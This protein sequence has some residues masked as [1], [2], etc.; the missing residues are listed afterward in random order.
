MNKPKMYWLLVAVLYLILWP[1]FVTGQSDLQIRQAQE[2]LKA[3][4]F[5][6][7][8]LDGK[9]GPKTQAALQQYQ[10][11]LGLPVTGELDE[12]TR[13]ALGVSKSVGPEWVIRPWKPSM[14]E[15]KWIEN[16][17]KEQQEMQRI[18]KESGEL[19]KRV[20]KA[21]EQFMRDSEAIWKELRQSEIREAHEVLKREGLDPGS[22]R[23]LLIAAGLNRLRLVQALLTTGADVNARDKDGHTALMAAVSSFLS[24]KDSA[25]VVKVLMAKGAD[26]NAKNNDGKTA[27]MLAAREKDDDHTAAILRLLLAN[28][29]DVNTRDR[30][31]RT[32]LIHAADK[33]TT[34][35]VLVLL[36]GG[37]DVNARDKDGNTALMAAANAWKDDISASAVVQALITKGGDVNAKNDK[38]QTAL[39]IAGRRTN[40]SQLLKQAGATK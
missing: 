37:A 3:A 28:G 33:G 36:D 12:A 24:K 30:D 15:K 27:L 14:E 21:V 4:G 25:D 26:V 13:E 5:D 29:A 8:P 39:E 19:H 6:P 34:T 18:F 7:G 40:I 10:T 31:G 11:S 9:L 35:A 16:V 32:A 1:D 17:K 23:H 20:D 22:N 2:L 38:G